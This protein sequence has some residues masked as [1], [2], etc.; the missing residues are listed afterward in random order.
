MCP[1][2]L[3]VRPEKWKKIRADVTRSPEVR[4]AMGF[5]QNFKHLDFLSVRVKRE[6]ERQTEKWPHNKAASKVNV[7][8]VLKEKAGSVIQNI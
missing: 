8:N 5:Q 1:I 2:M 7:R 6:R 3:S 4:W